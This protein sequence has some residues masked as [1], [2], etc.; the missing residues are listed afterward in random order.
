MES[1]LADYIREK[2]KERNLSA[3]DVARNAG[4]E[5]SPTIITKI[6]N[7]EVKK[8]GARTLALIAKGIGVPELDLFRVASGEDLG[9]PLHYQIY[10]ER[11]DGQ[12]LEDT[13][14]QF[15]EFY[16]K[17]YVDSFK[18]GKVERQAQIEKMISE[19]KNTRLAPVV[20]RIEPGKPTKDEVRR[21]INNDDVNEI[22][23][24]LK[25]KAG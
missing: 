16:F 17:Q 6:L 10:A 19:L 18:A 23:R 20:A 21:M 12:E 14:W 24:R 13:E 1:K 5:I 15:L 2:M 8:S 4:N 9:R 25:K 11:L 7:G 22:E 3:A